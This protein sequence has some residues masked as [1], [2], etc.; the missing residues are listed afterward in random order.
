MT[1][2]ALPVKKRLLILAPRMPFPFHSGE[3]WI[4]ALIQRLCA[5]YDVSLF[6][7]LPTDNPSAVAYG[8]SLE[9][10]VLRR[11]HA[12]PAPSTAEENVPHDFPDAVRPFFS[13]R[14]RAAL[15]RIIRE[16][17]PDLVHV[18]FFEMAHYIEAVPA[19]IPSL[20]TEHDV[21]H[22]W[23]RGSY[24]RDDGRSEEA[25]AAEV[26]RRRRH[27]RA[28]YPRFTALSALSKEDAGQ[29]GELV[30]AP[31][32]V[33]ALSADVDGLSPVR[34]LPEPAA[35]P[36]D[37]LFV[38][39]YRHYPNEDAALHLCRDIFPLL[40]RSRPAA[41]LRLAGAWPSPAV[42]ALAG[43]GVEVTGAAAS[44]RP[45]LKAARVFAAPVRLGSGVKGKVLEAFAAGLPVVA[46]PQVAAGFD[47]PRAHEAML[48]GEDPVRFAAAIESLLG[49]EALRLRLSH[50]ALE[51]ARERYDDRRA[52]Q[53]FERLYER[54]GGGGVRAPAIASAE[55]PG[56]TASRVL[57]ILEASVAEGRRADAAPAQPIRE[58]YLEAT[59]R[60]EL[61]CFMC[62]HWE[63]EAKDPGSVARELSVAELESAVGAS[64]LL[65]GVEQVVVTGG[66]AW[67]RADSARLVAVLARRFP[68]ARLIVL[69]HFGN[70]GLLHRRLR[71]LR[72]LG[73]SKLHLGSS[74]DG[75]GEAHDGVRGR[76]GVFAGLSRTVEMLRREHP[77]L[78]FGFTFT[79]TPRNYEQLER[80]FRFV[81]DELACDFGAQFVVQTAGI[82]AIVWPE[83][84]D[85]V[86]D[87]QLDAILARLCARPSSRQDVEE[88]LAG[89]GRP[90]IL[91]WRELIY[92]SRLRRIGIAREDLMDE[93]LSGSRYAML[94]PEGNV[95]FCPVGRKQI[96]GNVRAQTFDEI[97]TSEAAGLER[98]RIATCQCKAWI[99]CIANPI[100]DRLLTAG[101]R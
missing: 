25:A 98:A 38:G 68:Q 29:L 76:V 100:V 41:T 92:W 56:R 60:C 43:D 54:M 22:F 95:F 71:E 97:W 46:S 48:I 16:D 57:E 59:H 91:L 51:L 99:R 27:A 14:A 6:T 86:I 80:T 28:V 39:N 32:D 55:E 52:A 47:D 30:G 53:D 72:E 33:V 42:L 37:I 15:A 82:E 1:D 96:V 21:S 77:G 78:G 73:V 50:S 75:L 10:N 40:R 84:A 8:L 58:F 62:E 26:E 31:V 49:D 35:A 79:I 89:G 94:D 67:L 74:L 11:L 13:T 88:I 101:G 23:P 24:L 90:G 93:C 65:D 36:R 83:G 63:I 4:L 87:R 7:F 34:V 69:T 70:G 18:H 66:E 9:R 12:L 3:R 85:A 61:R 19:E 44:L 20:L 64:R 81:T 17:P 5:R 2:A 45:F